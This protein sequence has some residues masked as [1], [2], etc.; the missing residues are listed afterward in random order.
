MREAARARH[1]AT[2]LE[3]LLDRREQLVALVTDV[4]RVGP[5]RSWTTVASALISS[6]VP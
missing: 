2:D 3:V 1:A 5:S 4:A 6:V